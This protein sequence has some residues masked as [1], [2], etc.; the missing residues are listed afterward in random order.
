MK[1]RLKKSVDGLLELVVKTN[2]KILFA[3]YFPHYSFFGKGCMDTSSNLEASNSI[4]PAFN[5]NKRCSKG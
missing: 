1:N 2:N 5:L 3:R 4:Q